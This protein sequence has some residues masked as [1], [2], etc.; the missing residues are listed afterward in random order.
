MSAIALST[1]G[2]YQA[3]TPFF[4]E[5]TTPH[6]VTKTQLA[7]RRILQSPADCGALLGL[8]FSQCL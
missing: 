1:W 3:P 4:G 6:P 7:R 2:K 8:I 5:A